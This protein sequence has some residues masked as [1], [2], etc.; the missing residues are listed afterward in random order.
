MWGHHL[1]PPST[2][3]FVGSAYAAQ[4]G[5]LCP[6]LLG[7]VFQERTKLQGPLLDVCFYSTGRC[8]RVSRVFGDHIQQQRPPMCWCAT[9]IWRLTCAAHSSLSAVALRPTVHVIFRQQTRMRGILSSIMVTLCGQNSA[10]CKSAAVV[11]CG[12]ILFIETFRKYL[13]TAE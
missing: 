2:L 1:L 3:D 10:V 5:W 12:M 9:V 8:Q 7:P 6:P 11:L 4:T 13:C